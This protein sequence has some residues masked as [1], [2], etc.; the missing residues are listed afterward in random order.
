METNCKYCTK[1]FNQ[2][3]KDKVYC[4]RNCKQKASSRRTGRGWKHQRKHWIGFKDYVRK[5]SCELC[6]FLPQHICQLDVDHKDG[7]NKNNDH[8]NLQTICANCHRLK[9]Y[10]NK[11]WENK[12][13]KNIV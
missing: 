8:S 13:P 9:T 6:G 4:T 5:T 7:N 3:R 12:E 11:D 10:L 2:N 1:L